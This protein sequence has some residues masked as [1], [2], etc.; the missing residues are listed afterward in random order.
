MKF[1]HSINRLQKTLFNSSFYLHCHHASKTSSQLGFQILSWKVHHQTFATKSSQDHEISVS[2]KKLISDDF[3]TATPKILS[4]VGANLHNQE[5]HPLCII[6][7]Q[8]RD[9]FYRSSLN[10]RGNPLFS[11]YDNLSPVVTVW[12]NFDSVLVPG[13]HVSRRKG[14][15]YYLNREFMLRAHTSAHQHELVNSG[16]DA[17][18]V[19]GD[20]YRRDEIDATHFPVFHQMEGVRLFSDFELFDKY[21]DAKLKLFCNDPVRIQEKQEHHTL[22]AVKLVE[23]DLKQTLEGLAKYLFGE[24]IEVRWVVTDFPFTHPSFELE[25][26][27]QGEWLEVLGCGIMEQELL[28]SA[29]AGHKI[30]YAFGLGLERLAMVLFNIPDIRLFWSLDPRFINQFKVPDPQKVKFKPFSKFPPV[31]HDISFWCPDDGF[32]SNDFYDLVRSVAGETAEKVELIDDFLHPK[33]GRISHC[34]R[35]TYRSMDKTLTKDEVGLIHSDLT[36]K[37]NT[38]LGVEVRGK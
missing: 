38:L 6:K 28:H 25:I 12:Q 5:G 1:L 19:A 31:F 15:N 8:I 22:E 21:P 17:F 30:G 20:V 33:T 2:G 26:K 7:E 3:T 11:I 34:Y 24:E 9:Y 14:D 36:S 10:K 23:F 35:I 16:L 37:C 27:F 13:D 4:R 29:G 18:L 32:I